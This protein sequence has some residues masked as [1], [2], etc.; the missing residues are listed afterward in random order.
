MLKDRAVY[1]SVFFF[2]LLLLGLFVHRWVGND[3][4]GQRGPT[5]LRGGS[6]N[7]GSPEFPREITDIHEIHSF[8]KH[9]FKRIQTSR[10]NRVDLGSQ[11][12][13][14]PI[15]M[16][17]PQELQRQ[18]GS[19]VQIFFRKDRSN[20]D[21][22]QGSLEFSTPSIGVRTLIKECQSIE[23]YFPPQ[24]KIV[25]QNATLI[26][27]GETY[28]L[29]LSNG[30]S[31]KPIRWAW[32]GISKS[33]GAVPSLQMDY[34]GTYTVEPNSGTRLFQLTSQCEN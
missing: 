21:S 19:K 18:F 20:S 1:S 3:P 5:S 24:T 22:I 9:T 27:T 32:K 30:T 23:A 29:N 13:D 8:W 28:Q 6:G 15:S 14:S 17:F 33:V 34:R 2:T 12:K 11:F 25:Y 31:S 16:G 26:R 10:A 4:Q 7:P